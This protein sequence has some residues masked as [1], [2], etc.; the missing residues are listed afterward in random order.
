MP[1]LDNQHLEPAPD[2]P[3]D[4]TELRGNN[5]L[6]VFYIPYTGEIFLNYD[7]YY[8]RYNLY[9]RKI[10]TCEV[11]GATDLTYE[12]ALRSEAAARKKSESRFP[13]IWRKKAL[14]MIQWNASSLGH[15]VDQ[16]HDYFKEHMVI[17]EM[18]SVDFDGVACNAKVVNIVEPG[19][20]P[21]DCSDLDKQYIEF[22][23]SI[24]P[25]PEDFD[26]R[27]A[28]TTELMARSRGVIHLCTWEG[29]LL[30]DEESGG[31]QLKYVASAARCKRSRTVL[32]KANFRAFVK[33]SAAREGFMGAMW[34]I[35]SDLAQRY[36]ISE[37]PPNSVLSTTV[38]KGRGR[39]W[40]L[41]VRAP[42]PKMDKSGNPVPD[43]PVPIRHFGQVPPEQVSE[44]L[45]VWEFV[46]LFGKPLKLLPISFNDFVQ[47]I[48]HQ[49]LS[50]RC[51]YLHE[52]FA[53]LVH[54]V[55]KEW[56]A[57]LSNKDGLPV[58]PADADATPL[59]V[60]T[61]AEG[62]ERDAK[63]K[64]ELEM[65]MLYQ[66]K[67][68]GLSNDER[69]SIDQWYRWFP[70]RWADPV[71]DAVSG[72]STG[73]S[74]KERAGSA[75]VSDTGDAAGSYGSGGVNLAGIH[76][77]GPG[78]RYYWGV[79]AM[80]GTGNK[81][82]SVGRTRAMEVALIGVVRDC[83]SRMKCEGKWKI[84]AKLIG[85]V[86][87]A[88][89][90][91][92][93]DS[94]EGVKKECGD[95]GGAV[96]DNEEPFMVNGNGKRKVIEEED[97]LGLFGGDDD[98]DDD[99]MDEDGGDGDGNEGEEHEPEDDYDD[100]EEK[101]VSG[102][103]T[104]SR[105]KRKVAYNDSFD[106]DEELD[107]GKRGSR[108]RSSDKDPAGTA[109]A[110]AAAV[111]G[112]RAS[113]RITNRLSTGNGTSKDEDSVA[114]VKEREKEKE[115]ERAADLA[116]AKKKAAAEKA[117]ADK[118]AK[119]AKAKASKNSANTFDISALMGTAAK[120]FVGLSVSERLQVLACMVEEW[121]LGSVEIRDFV[122]YCN[123]V[124]VDR[125]RDIREMFREIRAME[126]TRAE[127]ESAE[128]M[129]EFEAAQ[130]YSETVDGGENNGENGGGD[131]DDGEQAKDE[132][133]AASAGNVELDRS[134]E[135]VDSNDGFGRM[136]SNNLRLKKLREEMRRKRELERQKKAEYER[137]RAEAREKEREKKRQNEARRK[138]E[139]AERVIIDK[140][141]HLDGQLRM[142]QAVTR[143]YPL[144]R[145]RY[146]NRYWWFD[147]GFGAS[148]PD[149]IVF[150]LAQ[151]SMPLNYVVPGP[152]PV[153]AGYL[154][155]EEFQ[156]LMKDGGGDGE[157]K[158]LVE[159]DITCESG[160]W[161]YF[162]S[163]EQLD[164]LMRWLDPRGLRE[165]WLLSRLDEKKAALI[166][167][168]ELREKAA[169]ASSEAE[170]KA[171]QSE[172]ARRSSRNKNGPND[173][174]ALPSYLQYNNTWS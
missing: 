76:A 143:L 78:A 73:G 44:L 172:F 42:R 140:K 158:A 29:R 63:G 99:K 54:L 122:E 87:D 77:V 134:E 96:P 7:D 91:S 79:G 56:S 101:E 142:N 28:V 52:L 127:F 24:Q 48:S 26:K 155:V 59:D 139:E 129:K 3:R 43:Q 115:K 64:E 71:A 108:R 69:V 147:A 27:M 149:T 167:N 106:E 159:A 105:K 119:A 146:F 6:E 124:V 116:A 130:P 37:E 113:S 112:T 5:D 74:G 12:E 153:A 141:T 117:K 16:L 128:R 107:V 20:E 10:F 38:K 98:D 156:G 132:D 114:A 89:V 170:L 131:G 168:F 19:D 120:G 90:G 173:I 138:I 21:A 11:T 65:F 118:A 36:D 68:E 9:R 85:G 70:G 152:L 137:I 94:M 164:N 145:D 72:G 75:A 160:R 46:Y 40:K 4:I 121:C 93:G 126:Q 161:G 97:E 123:D 25:P 88:G 67:V 45:A 81:V 50:P 51:N 49:T 135:D 80:P 2:L 174:K 84:L 55:C 13:E 60:G 166:H 47:S 39:Q 103:R 102:R 8:T 61:P 110:L 35:R 111:K 58:I 53:S 66:G 163:I 169:A 17:G 125:K 33:D 14:E 148:H 41:L 1:L 62:G 154:F 86:V 95:E 162:G 34:T 15:L 157:R 57:R 151:A 32:S 82:S 22:L 150:P 23:Q 144:G 136:T 31:F 104:S 83:V 109:A 18:I 30:T 165:S 100:E 92:E 133:G 171:I